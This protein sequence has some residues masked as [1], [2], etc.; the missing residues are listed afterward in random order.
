M[1][2][3]EKGKRLPKKKGRKRTTGHAAHL[4]K[5][6]RWISGGKEKKKKKEK[7]L[8]EKERKR[9]KEH[10]T[11]GTL[12]GGPASGLGGE[13]EGGESQPGGGKRGKSGLWHLVSRKEGPRGLICPQGQREKKMGNRPR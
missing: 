1:T 4:K 12:R 5:M 7:R 2:E 8:M 13:G 6:V 3:G 9:K 11:S 10:H